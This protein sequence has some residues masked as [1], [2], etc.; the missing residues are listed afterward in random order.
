MERNDPG[1]VGNAPRFSGF[2]HENRHSRIPLQL[3][4]VRKM[5]GL[6]I[7]MPFLHIA[8]SSW[9]MQKSHCPI[10]WCIIF[11]KTTALQYYCIYN[12]HKTDVMDCHILK[13]LNFNNISDISTQLVQL[14]SVYQ[15]LLN[16]RSFNSPSSFSLTLAYLN[17]LY[18]PALQNMPLQ[19][20]IKWSKTHTLERTLM[21]Y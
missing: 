9:V 4:N 3:C 17:V 5:H 12:H 7:S 15:V 13:W 18:I 10:I 8:L 6:E 2:P 11:K 21:K 20:W 14:W 19:E 1:L 16:E